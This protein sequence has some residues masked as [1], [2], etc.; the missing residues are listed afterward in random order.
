M[1]APSLLS[2]FSLAVASDGRSC[3]WKTRRKG[4]A[5]PSF[6]RTLGAFSVFC[7]ASGAMISSGLFVLPGL[8]FARCGP[9]VTM[10]YLLSG[11]IALPALLSKCELATA[12]P[13]SG[14]DYFFIERSLGSA[15]GTLGGLATWFS[16]SFKRR[17]RPHRA[18]RFGQ[19]PGPRPCPRKP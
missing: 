11:L 9:A 12:M 8:A 1:G 18:R 6:A 3:W 13:K 10:A 17:L 2:P 15:W 14:G 7:I 19:P 4:T 16:L 5:W